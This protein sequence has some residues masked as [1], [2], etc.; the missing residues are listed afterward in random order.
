ME[1]CLEVK[2][3]NLI[4]MPRKLTLFLFLMI[5]LTGCSVK[6]AKFSTGIYSRTNEDI[7]YILVSDIW[8]TDSK[9]GHL[10]VPAT[11]KYSLT[12]TGRMYFNITN[13]GIG[14]FR[15][16]KQ[17][18]TDVIVNGFVGQTSTGHEQFSSTVTKIVNLHKNDTLLMEYKSLG[19]SNAGYGGNTDGETG[20]TVTYLGK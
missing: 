14:L 4:D 10:I 12:A 7:P 15:I 17:N 19:T 16:K 6:Y 2:K 11:G 1:K 9:L 3:L 18:T 13:H 8:V 20:I 5:A